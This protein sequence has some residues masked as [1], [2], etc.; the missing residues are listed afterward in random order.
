MELTAVERAAQAAAVA[1][2]AGLSRERRRREG[3]VHTAPELARFA[4][5]AADDLLRVELG[6]PAGLA[7]ERVSLVDPACGPGAFLAAALSVAKGRG[8]APRAVLALDRDPV[9]LA[10]AEEALRPEL[11]EEGWSCA[12]EARDTLTE[13]DPEGIA[14][15][16]PIA[17]VLG[18]P[19][20][21]GSAQA[22][23]APRSTVCSRTSAAIGD[24]RAAERA[25]DRCACRRLRALRPRRLRD[26]LPRARRRGDRAGHER[27]V[28]RR[29]GA[30][31]HA[32]RAAALLRRALRA[33]P[34][35]QRAPRARTRG[36]ARR[37]RLRRT[38]VG[39]RAGRVEEGGADAGQLASVR[40][41]RVV[42]TLEQKIER[43]AA[44]RIGDADFKLLTVAGAQQRFV[45]SAAP[46]ADYA[47]W[48]S[49]A[50]AMPFHQEGVQ[51]NRDAA[52]ID[53]D[54]EAL[55]RR[56]RAFAA[57]ERRRSSRRSGRRSRTTDRRSRGL[58]LRARSRCDP[59]GTRG[60]LLQ[61]IAYRPFDLRWFATVRSGL[62]SPAPAAARRDGP[63]RLRAGHRPQGS[64]QR[65]LARL[66]REP[67]RDRQLLPVLAQLVPRA[68]VPDARLRKVARTWPRRRAS[69][70]R[71]ESAAERSRAREFACLRA[72]VLGEPHYRT[73]HDAKRS[74]STHPQDPAAGRRA[75]LRAP[76]LRAGEQLV[77]LY[78]APDEIAAAPTRA[79]AESVA[80][81]T[82]R[83]RRGVPA[84]PL[85]ERPVRGEAQQ[86]HA[87]LRDELSFLVADEPSQTWVERPRVTG[88][89]TPAAA[90]PTAPRE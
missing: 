49:L 55:L 50:D 3:I 4:A 45:P 1:R 52:V 38:P 51:T 72:R 83:R 79:T 85:S 29:P 27:L 25:Q 76:A 41:Q 82:D 34:R 77:E 62:P 6:E 58:R 67:A 16:A 18:N 14:Q 7:S 8:S 53:G 37:Q 21:I 81:S 33:R 42:G 59:D 32:R 13:I 84:V 9:A 11:T 63:L 73:E 40:Y 60:E 86:A 69:I 61:R 22:R 31:R 5:R 68:R 75:A 20:W 12:F 36:R 74:A 47:S 30:P 44:A 66:R 43:I 2:D 78:C 48:P 10:A 24:G 70:R 26:R 71:A 56:L 89:A 88:R 46:R 35:R 23:S 80:R 65:T 17:V 57:G 28:P 19:P 54:R 64:R 87:P 15:R 39:L 90:F